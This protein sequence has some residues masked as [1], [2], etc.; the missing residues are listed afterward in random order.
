MSNQLIRDSKVLLL[1]NFDV[2]NTGSEY[3]MTD[4]YHTQ[5]GVP[6]ELVGAGVDPL[7]Y[8]D[9]TLKIGGV[10][11][12]NTDNSTF[13]WGKNYFKYNP[14]KI[15]KLTVRVHSDLPVSFG[16]VGYTSKPL[17]DLYDVNFNTSSYREEVLNI[18]RYMYSPDKYSVRND[19]VINS[20]AGPR[21]INH[22]A[23]N[24]NVSVPS[25]QELEGFISGYAAPNYNYTN[26]F[27][28]VPT[29]DTFEFKFDQTD[30]LNDIKYNS[31]VPN[32][33]PVVSVKFAGFY[34]TTEQNYI[35]PTGTGITTPLPLWD[36]VLYVTPY[37]FVNVGDTNKTKFTYVDY[38]KFEE[39]NGSYLD[40]T[41]TKIAELP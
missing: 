34:S 1:S 22:Y 23:T 18:C 38:I 11:Y 15:Y 27:N 7:S 31:I 8:N 20:N 35:N 2:I 39:L 36:S 29:V 21:T 26:V 5:S 13:I 19:N 37:I 14:N 16:L 10:G 41:D 32:T 3:H 25:Y 6:L 24:R 12:G 28:N 9:N 4:W 40:Y 30:A 33:A 17:P